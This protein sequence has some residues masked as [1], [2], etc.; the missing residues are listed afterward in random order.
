MPTLP[1]LLSLWDCAA[2]TCSNAATLASVTTDANGSFTTPINI[3]ADATVGHAY[4][5]AATGASSAAFATAL[6][7]VNT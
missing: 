2:A 7:T 4:P 5:I 3:P 1:A 6:Y